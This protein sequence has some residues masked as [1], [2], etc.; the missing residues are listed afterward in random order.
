M[1][2]SKLKEKEYFLDLSDSDKKIQK[3]RFCIISSYGNLACKH[4][5]MYF[6]RNREV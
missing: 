3:M 5:L 4:N 2:N 6:V 1:E